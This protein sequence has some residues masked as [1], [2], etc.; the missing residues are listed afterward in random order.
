MQINDDET[1]LYSVGNTRFVAMYVLYVHTDV[2]TM[3]TNM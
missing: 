2:R 1:H 3:H